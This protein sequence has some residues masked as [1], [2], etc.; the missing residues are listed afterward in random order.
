MSLIVVDASVAAKWY[1]ATSSEELTQE[2][3]GLL[4]RYQEGE[5]RFVVPDLFFAEVANV[6]WK[7]VRLGVLGQAA[8]QAAITSLQER[9]VPTV[10]STGLLHTAF[11]IATTFNSSVYDSLYVALAIESNGQFVTADKR[12][13]NA[14]SPHCPI[15][16]LG[17]L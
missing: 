7:A 5:L 6:L 9:K 15:R 4:N 1:L 8:A 3:F 11:V 13:V 16:W 10:S 2:A 17:A 14:L 12:L